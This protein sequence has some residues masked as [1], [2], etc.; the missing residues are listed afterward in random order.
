VIN[1][2][3]GNLLPSAV[4]PCKIGGAPVLNLDTSDEVVFYFFPQGGGLSLGG[5]GY[6]H[7]AEASLVAYD[8]APGDTD[9]AGIFHAEFRVR[10]G[11]T[12]LSFPN[13]GYIRLIIAAAVPDPVPGP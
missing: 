11:T 7:D 4:W 1:V 10:W 13:Y 5:P 2:K 9:L 3:Q 8:W 12:W 6:V